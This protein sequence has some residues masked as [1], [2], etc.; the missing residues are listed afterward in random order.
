MWTQ[1][2][3]GFG[4]EAYMDRRETALATDGRARNST[5]QPQTSY[6]LAVSPEGLASPRPW[7]WHSAN[8]RGEEVTTANT[9]CPGFRVKGGP[10]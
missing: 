2:L 9:S 1:G 4:S 8:V 6:S 10:G 7:H 3:Q 5:L